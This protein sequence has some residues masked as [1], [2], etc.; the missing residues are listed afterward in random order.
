MSIIEDFSGLF[1]S[2]LALLDARGAGPDAGLYTVDDEGRVL[3]IGAPF[4]S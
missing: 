2:D 3:K 1:R 4:P